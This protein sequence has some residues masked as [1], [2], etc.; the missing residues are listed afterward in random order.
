MWL[1]NFHVHQGNYLGEILA[2]AGERAIS[3]Q[4]S[5]GV[6]FYGRF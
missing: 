3:G 5:A 4:L 1:S 2:P 6:T